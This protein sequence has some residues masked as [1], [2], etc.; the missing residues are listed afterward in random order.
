MM[1][2]RIWGGWDIV[3][4]VLEMV[5]AGVLCIAPEPTG[6]TK[7]GCVVFGMH[8]ADTA[9][10]GIR[11]AWTGRDTATLTQQGAAKLAETMRAPPDMANNIGLSLDIGVGFGLAGM[12]KAARVSSIAFG[13]LNLM[14]QEANTAGGRGGH[15]IRKHVGQTEVQLR[16]RLAR[17]PDLREASTFP[18]LRIAEDAISK[19]LALEANRV[20]SWA[21]SRTRFLTLQRNVGASVGKVLVRNTGKLHNGSNVVVVLVKGEHNGMPFYILTAYVKS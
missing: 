9:W 20:S 1:A 4:G 19:V 2:N 8:G 16:A 15:T 17:E 7:V 18:N 5:G 6:L 10:R 3:G 13:R 11:Q 21:S 14:Q 12:M